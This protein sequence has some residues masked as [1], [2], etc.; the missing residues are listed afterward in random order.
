MRI[1][2]K[3]FKHFSATFA[4][5]LLTSFDFS[6]LENCCCW[7][8]IFFECVMNAKTY[9]R[10][11]CLMCSMSF[12]IFSL[13]LSFLLSY[14]VSFSLFLFSSLCRYVGFLWRWHTVGVYRKWLRYSAS[15]IDEAPSSWRLVNAQPL[16]PS[17]NPSS[18]CLGLFL[19]RF[20]RDIIFPRDSVNFFSLF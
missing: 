19:R 9:R 10:R 5:H 13:P 4:D 14:F 8:I 15:Q 7:K 1:L 11:R 16:F 3:R 20:S 6:H 17:V 12:V 18:L 2:A